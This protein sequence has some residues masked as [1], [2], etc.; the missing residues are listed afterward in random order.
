[1][2]PILVGLAGVTLYGMA[3]ALRG[4]G[5]SFGDAGDATGPFRFKMVKESGNVKT[6]PIP[7]VYT[8]NRTCPKSCI[9][10]T[11]GC[12]GQGGKVCGA[13]RD[14]VANGKPLPQ[15]TK[16]IKQIKP[17]TLWRYAVVGDFPGHGDEIDTEAFGKIVKASQDAKAHGFS[18]T[19]KPVLHGP[20]ATQ[21]REAIAKANE[22]SA[23]NTQGLTVNLSADSLEH[24]DALAELG[25]GPVAVVLPY[26]TP[27]SLTT[28]GGRKVQQCPAQSRSCVTCKKCGLCAD[29]KRKVIVGL[30][31]HGANTPFVSKL[32]KLSL[33]EHAKLVEQLAKVPLKWGCAPKKRKA[34]KGS[35]T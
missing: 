24:A 15:L 3:K 10:R 18:Y 23:K 21:N 32:A 29:A 12:Y 27:D 16:F 31:A 33:D 2:W 11:K 4:G 35:A 5:S 17:D 13:W 7:V 25:I 20:H 30:E 14:T 26:G 6:G 19:H 9:W 8:D 34:P 28:P 22:Y 1:M